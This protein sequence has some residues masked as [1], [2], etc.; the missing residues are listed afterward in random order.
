[1]RGLLCVAHHY[2]LDTTGER[3]KDPWSVSLGRA[4]RGRSAAFPHLPHFQ[5]EKQMFADICFQVIYT[6][7]LGILQVYLHYI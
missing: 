6:T 5:E 4:S 7:K 1:M 3:K 2:S